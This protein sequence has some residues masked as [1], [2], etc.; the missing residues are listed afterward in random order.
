MVDEVY[1]TEISRFKSLN[2]R[3][4]IKSSFK[5]AKRNIA[6]IILLWLSN[7][8]LSKYSY[9]ESKDNK[10]VIKQKYVENLYQYINS[11][12]KDNNENLDNFIKNINEFELVTNQLEPIQVA[13]QLVWPLAEISFEDKNLKDNEERTG[14]KRYPKIIS[15]TSN[16]DLIHDAFIGQ[17]ELL[18]LILSKWLF[19]KGNIDLRWDNEIEQQAEEKLLKLLSLIS[20]QTAFKIVAN[21]KGIVFQKNGIYESIANNG[22]DT[23]VNISGDKE[24]KG[25]LRVMSAAIKGNIE[26]FLESTTRPSGHVKLKDTS[27]ESIKSFAERI[28]TGQKLS[29][30]DLESE[31]ETSTALTEKEPL[32][33]SINIGKNIIYYGAPGTGKSYR[34]TNIIRKNGISDYNPK[35]GNE[36][37]ERVTLHPEYSYSEFVGQIMPVVKSTSGTDKTIT[38]DFQ[39]GDFTRTL[40]KAYDNLDQPV[41]LIMEEMSRANVAAVFG[42]LFQLL[43]RDEDGFSE[44]AITNT[45]IAKYVFPEKNKTNIYLPS[46]LMIIGTVNTSDQNVF[47]MDTAFKRRFTWEYVSPVVDEEGF[48][49]NPDIKISDDVTVS[50]YTLYMTL[51]DFITRELG[52]TEDKQIGPYFI[53]FGNS[54]MKP[55]ELIKDKLLQ[56]LWEDVDTVARRMNGGARSLFNSRIASFADLYDSFGKESVFSNK[57]I[58]KLQGNAA[59]DTDESDDADGRAED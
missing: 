27:A 53:K 37:V 11:S 46:N 48:D 38:Y 51:N 19:L 6:L 31:L 34:L 23:L 26:P 10:I 25:P 54:T 57:F 33:T 22:K 30:V 2:A 8:K 40:K 1:P 7:G 14:S 21:G 24:I 50:W 5:N 44:Y 55:E 39:P 59:D 43:D 56:Y 52:L 49:N 12:I 3:L 58:E 9:F 4:G 32:S 41:F 45:M 13:F 47:A 18:K 20:D 15:Y 35:I 36:F 17:E 16:V 28:I 42:D 29:N